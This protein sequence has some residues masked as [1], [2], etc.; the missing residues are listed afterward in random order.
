MQVPLL[1]CGVTWHL[2]VAGPA[3]LLDTCILSL[4][5]LEDIEVV[6]MCTFLLPL[7]L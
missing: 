7:N 6:T 2:L 3:F 5:T 1:P 4:L